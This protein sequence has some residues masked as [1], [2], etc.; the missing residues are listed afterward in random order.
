MFGMR[1]VWG[2]GSP[3]KGLLL[4]RR[5]HAWM[6]HRSNVWPDAITTGSIM[7]ACVIGQMSSTDGSLG[8]SV[9]VTMSESQSIEFGV[10]GLAV[11][12]MDP[13]EI[14]SSSSGDPT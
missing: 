13:E 8:S 3:V 4:D 11:V 9:T 14:I 1:C 2:S 5:N 10:V 7:T 6:A 12:S